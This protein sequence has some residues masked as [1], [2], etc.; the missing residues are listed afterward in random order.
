NVMADDFTDPGMLRPRILKPDANLL[1]RLFEVA[2]WHYYKNPFDPYFVDGMPRIWRG[3]ERTGWYTERAFTYIDGDRNTFW[4]QLGFGSPG[5]KMNHEFWTFDLGTLVPLERFQV[6]TPPDSVTHRSGEPFSNFIPRSGE[7]S[8]ADDE[9]RIRLELPGQQNDCHLENKY[10]CS[11]SY[12][13]LEFLLGEVAENV[14]APIAVPFPTRYLRYLRW[15]TFPDGVATSAGAGSWPFVAKLAYAEFEVYGRGAAAL[16]RYTTKAIDLGRPATLGKIELGVSRW[17]LDENLEPVQTPDAD[18]G[19]GVRVKTGTTGDYR[20]YHTLND[21]L[22]LVVVDRGEYDRLQ[23]QSS[24]GAVVFVGSQGPIT[25]DFENWSPWSGPLAESGSRPGLASGRW[26]AVQIEMRSGKPSDFARLDSLSIEIIPLLADRVVG[27]VAKS[28]DGLSPLASDVPLGEEVELSYAI[29]AEFEEVAGGFDAVRIG[30]PLPPTF[31]SLRIG[32]PLD[33]VAPDSVAI[34]GQGLTVYLPRRIEAD[35]D[36]RIGFG[37]A[38]YTVAEELDGEV[39]NRTQP[40]RGQPVIGGGRHR[41]DR[42]QQPA[43][44][45]FGERGGADDLRRRHPPAR[46][47]PQR[48]RLQRFNGDPVRPVRRARNRRR[49]RLLRPE[50]EPGEPHH[51][52]ERRPGYARARMGRKGRGGKGAHTGGVPVR[53]RRRDRKRPLP[54]HRPGGGGLLKTDHSPQG[55]RRGVAGRLIRE[56][57]RQGREVSQSFIR[58]AFSVLPSFR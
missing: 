44:A 47:H 54:V 42:Q 33:E 1:P 43:G 11:T 46:G 56:V 38:L 6:Q 49:G 12:R 20:Q 48:R 57:M 51:G 18:A 39:F 23:V 7:L 52:H 37:T 17:R 24:H 2:T 16:S 36:L 27:E 55:R 26:F 22:E 31:R 45:R 5:D 8:G 34:D 13:P 53:S 58:S 14:T 30:T 25:D 29:S 40:G 15:R 3:T 9:E 35:E 21:Q 19:I 4:W 10:I 50:R 32:T 41:G 28:G